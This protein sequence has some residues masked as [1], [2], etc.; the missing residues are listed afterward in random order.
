MFV[1]P[2]QLWYRNC[3][4]ARIESLIPIQLSD[5]LRNELIGVIVT[6]SEWRQTIYPHKKLRAPELGKPWKPVGRA[7]P[8]G[9]RSKVQ[10]PRSSHWTP[11]EPIFITNSLPNNVE[12]F[13]FWS[14]F[15]QYW[16]LLSSWRLWWF[17]FSYLD[18]DL[19]LNLDLSVYLAMYPL[20]SWPSVSDW[21]CFGWHLSILNS[22]NLCGRSIVFDLSSSF[23]MVCLIPRS[24]YPLLF[25]TD[26][27]IN[28][29]LTFDIDVKNWLSPVTIANGQLTTQSV[30]S[31]HCH[32]IEST[33]HH[34]D[35]QYGSFERAPIQHCDTTYVTPMTYFRR[36]WVSVNFLT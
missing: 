35:I 19:N 2:H 6:V 22:F 30:L 23:S 5:T 12:M 33:A 18:L 32:K 4:M 25:L 3:E 9:Q 36:Q 1:F 21:V 8:M 31:T 7:F 13:L 20:K 27:I 34:R 16:F 17:I 26:A 15:R 11:N 24:L 14:T 28:L 29:Y 10:G